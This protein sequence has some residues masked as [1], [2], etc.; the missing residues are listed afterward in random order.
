MV[1]YEPP[2][3]CCNL[4]PGDMSS[5]PNKERMINMKRTFFVLSLL[6]LS[7][8]IGVTANADDYRP[9]IEQV[10]SLYDQYGDYDE[11]PKEGYEQAI[12]ILK[13][14][15][16]LSDRSFQNTS[17][18][19][20]QTL[21]DDLMEAFPGTY[22]G[23]LNRVIENLWGESDFW[24]LSDKAWYT[25]LLKAH[26]QFT[27][28]D[29]IYMLPTDA[30]QTEESIRDLALQQI[31]YQ[32]NISPEELA[33]ADLYYSY[34]AMQNDPE[35]TIW[36]IIFCD[37]GTKDRLFTVMF[38][39]DG[40]MISSFMTNRI[41][42]EEAMDAIY[43]KVG[44]FYMLSLEEQV[45]RAQFERFPTNGLPGDDDISQEKALEIANNALITNGTTDAA[46]LDQLDI[47]FS[48][49]ITGRSDFRF[50]YWTVY[51]VDSVADREKYTVYINSK[52]G[53]ILKIDIA[54]WSIPGLG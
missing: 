24:S 31:E 7:I 10:G 43:P 35:K 25:Q 27:K 26:N 15:G 52:D 17:S 40:T 22:T 19:S 8:M 38:Y 45:E 49:T 18:Q 36:Q 16:M 51:Y 44:R 21:R 11:W 12:T 30:Q 14:A 32:F 37:P 2:D 34:Y 53:T 3:T 13:G 47:Y 54:D 6:V 50:P 4:L 23:F 39:D 1:K 41:L 48:F 28:Y 33:D 9:L 42:D 5:G 20:A 46:G 29:R